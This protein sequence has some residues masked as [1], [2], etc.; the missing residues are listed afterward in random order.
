MADGS[1]GPFLNPWALS[2]GSEVCEPLAAF[3]GPIDPQDPPGVRARSSE[4]RS[5]RVGILPSEPSASSA[6]S[7]RW[8]FP[9]AS[10]LTVRLT[11]GPRQCP[12]RQPARGGAARHPQRRTGGGLA[13][14]LDFSH[15]D[16]RGG[17][18]PTRAR[19]SKG[20]S[21][22]R[23]SDQPIERRP[24]HGGRTA[25]GSRPAT[26]TSPSNA[27]DQGEQVRAEV[28]AA[29]VPPVPG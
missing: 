12:D 19:E 21:P 3:A 9:A 6:G 16:R 26:V 11:V 15:P 2:I 5:W 14:S 18:G 13:L 25:T 28:D 24:A 1:D 10:G 22:S 7:L 23:N 4:S 27:Y 20:D 29:V 8:L 17:V